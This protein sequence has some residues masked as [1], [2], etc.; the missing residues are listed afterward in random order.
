MFSTWYTSAMSNQRN[1]PVRIRSF[2]P[3][4]E[5]KLLEE[6]ILEWRALGASAAWNA[7]YDMLGWW[8][9]AR[10]LD[11]E[12]QRVDRSHIEVLP[13]P[14]LTNCTT[15]EAGTLAPL[16]DTADA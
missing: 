5:E 11:P 3:E 7:I 14:W 10:G 4:D 1:I 8:F 16:K 2:S 9:T 15:T 12:I 6:T 13:V